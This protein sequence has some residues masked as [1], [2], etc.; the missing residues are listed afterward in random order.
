MWQTCVANDFPKEKG[1]S[2]PNYKLFCPSPSLWN[3]AVTLLNMICHRDIKISWIILRPHCQRTK[4]VYV[5]ITY[6]IFWDVLCIQNLLF[7]LN[8]YTF[9]YK[10]KIYWILGFKSR[11]LSTWDGVTDNLK[12]N[13]WVSHSRHLPCTCSV[14]SC[15]TPS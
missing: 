6:N 3:D 13:D 10:F 2:K 14:R 15:S 5:Q 12:R 8:W 4:L 9:W 7:V 1:Y 11:Q